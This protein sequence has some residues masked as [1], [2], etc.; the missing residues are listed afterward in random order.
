[1]AKMIVTIDGPA[2]VGK[3]TVSRMV[4]GQVGAAFLDTGAIF[5]VTKLWNCA[6]KPVI[7][8]NTQIIRVNI[9]IP[10]EIIVEQHLFFQPVIN[11]Q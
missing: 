2:G 7:E 8:E 4:A 5:Y 6:I 1:M 9:V 10:V 11:P 3:S